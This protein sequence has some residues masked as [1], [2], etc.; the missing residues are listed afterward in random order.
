[1]MAVVQPTSAHPVPFV[2]P[3]EVAMPEF[4]SKQAFRVSKPNCKISLTIRIVSVIKRG[5]PDLTLICF[6]INGTPTKALSLV[7]FCTTYPNRV[8][9]AI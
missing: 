9:I 4:H 1:M 5:G 2:F 6:T 8:Q 3:P 7:Q